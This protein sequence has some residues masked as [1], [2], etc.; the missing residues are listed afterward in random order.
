MRLC[1]ISSQGVGAC[2]LNAESSLKN[3]AECGLSLGIAFRGH[4]RGTVWEELGRELLIALVSAS[5]G[6]RV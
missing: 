2:A 6:K 4:E 5:A 1:R 3:N